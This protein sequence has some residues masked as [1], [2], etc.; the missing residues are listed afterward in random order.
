MDNDLKTI[1]E[2]ASGLVGLLKLPPYLLGALA[3]ASG[4]LLFLPDDVIDKL[5]MSSF[6]EQYGFIAGIVF[7]VSIAI[8]T[9]HA[10]VQLYKK[11]S[12]K[13]KLKKLKEAQTSFLA[14]IDGDK[15]CLIK[16][17][18]RVPSH[19]LKL[20]MY[21]GIVSELQYYN[22]ISPAGQTHLVDMSAP[23]ISYFLQPWV[24]QRIDENNELRQKFDS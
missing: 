12:S 17:F 21:S 9:V 22:V 7:I 2:K 13:V 1:E 16:E 3:A 4:I 23:E 11:V 8:L 5:Y 10:I 24:A 15:L 19:T 20:P 14:K 18:M 6:R